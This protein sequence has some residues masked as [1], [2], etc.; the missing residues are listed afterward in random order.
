MGGSGS[1]RCR[2][3]WGFGGFWAG[4]RRVFSG[5]REKVDG[6]CVAGLTNWN[7]GCDPEMAVYFLSGEVVTLGEHADKRYR[8]YL[9]GTASDHMPNEEPFTQ[10]SR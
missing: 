6:F 10:L 9:W 1:F 5:V 2:F 7:A 3:S 4:L 8:E